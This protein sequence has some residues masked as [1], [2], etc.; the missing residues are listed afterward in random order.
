MR[1][2]PVPC[3]SDNYAYLVID[4]RSQNAAVVD[5]SEAAPVLVAAEREGVTITELWLTHHHFDHVGGNEGILRAL[6]PRVVRGSAYDRRERRVPGQTVAHDDDDRFDFEGHEVR[7]IE[8]PGHTLGAISFL[9]EGHLFSG[10]TLFLAGCGRVFEGTMEM[11][12]D[13]LATLR[14]LP[15]DT[16]VWC[17]HE[18]TVKNLEYAASVE[19][20]NRDIAVRLSAARE[21]R[22][23]GAFT[24][25]GT[26][27]SEKLANPFFR[28]D[29]PTVAAGRDPVSTFTALR[30]GKGRF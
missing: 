26:I 21:E 16:E 28:F 11:M 30:Q 29:V 2:V 12:K 13:S 25:P 20:D 17:G 4:E 1:I 24:V 3:L 14:A 22:A 6:G 27:G 8:N 19:P 15:D 5:P 23:T 7:V 9:V 18:Y 10:D